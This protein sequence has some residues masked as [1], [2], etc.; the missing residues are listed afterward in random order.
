MAMRHLESRQSHPPAW[1]TGEQVPEQV[2]PFGMLDD[3]DGH[4]TDRVCTDSLEPG[5]VLAVT[6][7]NTRYRLTV[8]DHER[9]ALITGGLL[10]PDPTEVRI[11]GALDRGVIPQFGWIVVGLQLELSMGGRLITTSTV[12][13]VHPIA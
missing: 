11:E 2:Q 3:I 9:H 13:S 4:P 8:L 6:T 5:T 7:R 1:I 12:Q 10:F